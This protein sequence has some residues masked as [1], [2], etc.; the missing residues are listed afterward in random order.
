MNWGVGW[1]VTFEEQFHLLKLSLEP[2][3]CLMQA[4]SYF[5]LAV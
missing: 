1:G 2:F 5:P 3:H 4:L